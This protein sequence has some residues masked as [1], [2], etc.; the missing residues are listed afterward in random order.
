[1]QD[2][3]EIKSDVQTPAAVQTPAKPEKT[4]VIYQLQQ[5]VLAGLGASAPEYDEDGEEI[6]KAETT[7]GRNYMP[8]EK[9]RSDQFPQAVLKRLLRREKQEPGE[10]I[11]EVLRVPE[12]QFTEALLY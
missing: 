9:I 8:G 3:T 2:N 6:E 5:P 11:T 1:M 12:S 7:I 10:V 4:I